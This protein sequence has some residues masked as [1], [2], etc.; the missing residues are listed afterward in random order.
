MGASAQ[1]AIDWL[2]AAAPDP[3]ACRR[4][5]ERSPTGVATLP[6]G[7]RWD[8][9]IVPGPLGRTTLDVL[10]DSPRTR[11]GPVLADHGGRRVGFFVPTG[12]AAR[13]VG[14]NTRC[15]GPGTWI[16]VPHP[17]RSLPRSATP[18]WLVAPDGSGRLNDPATLELALHEA[19]ADYL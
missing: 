12:T 14:K 19:A 11:P 7:V 9:L 3:S 17:T 16:V 5:W 15:V 8:V 18:T 1:H 10:L 2:A 4:E 13:W 6:A